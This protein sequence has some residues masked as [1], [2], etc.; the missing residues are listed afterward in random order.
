MLG[1]ILKYP[2]IDVNLVLE[3][4]WH[5]FKGVGTNPGICFNVFVHMCSGISD[6]H[7]H[8]A[9]VY[10]S[11]QCHAVP[12]N[13][14]EPRFEN[15]AIKLCL[16]IWRRNRIFLQFVRKIRGEGSNWIE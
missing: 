16:E 12:M 6:R 10:T 14:Y 1:Y 7:R 11:C 15:E 13:L 5:Y 9:L 2:K 3:K 8:G 4:F